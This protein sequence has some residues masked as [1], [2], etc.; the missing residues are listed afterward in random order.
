M[1]SIEAVYRG[2]P[3]VGMPIFFDQN[4]NIKKF[5]AKGLGVKLDYRTLTK[6]SVLSAVREIL[7][8][9]R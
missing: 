5:L 2:V 9:D 7:N 3:V 6:E 1:S 4:A 8:N